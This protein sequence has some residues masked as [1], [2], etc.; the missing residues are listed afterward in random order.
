MWCAGS[1]EVEGDCLFFF[2][3]FFL[4]YFL[5]FPWERSNRGVGSGERGDWKRMCYCPWPFT[6]LRGLRLV[7]VIEVILMPVWPMGLEGASSF[8]SAACCR[9]NSSSKERAKSRCLS[10]LDLVFFFT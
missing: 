3:F 1:K 7:A 10:S 8:W 6:Y 2:C 4:S 9:G 5:L